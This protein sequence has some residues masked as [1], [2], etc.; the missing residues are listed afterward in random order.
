VDVGRAVNPDQVEAQLEGGV[1][2][3]AGYALMEELHLREGTIENPDLSRYII[4]TSLDVP[5]V[6]PIIVE[7]PYGGG[8]YGAKGFGEIPMIGTPA[9]I[10]NAVAQAISARPRRLPVRPEQILE[11]GESGKEGS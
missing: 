7:A 3:A 8:P 9:A 11:L 4:P 1:V 6:H 10:A 5:R 2:Q